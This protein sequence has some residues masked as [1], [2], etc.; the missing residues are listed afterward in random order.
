MSSASSN[1]GATIVPFPESRAKEPR[2]LQHGEPLG[3]VLLFTG[4][5][6]ERAA[7]QRVEAVAKPLASRRK[8]L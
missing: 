3:I 7:E 8:R 6:Y 2:I 5:R 4:V 1:D